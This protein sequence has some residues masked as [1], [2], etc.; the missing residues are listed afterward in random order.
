MNSNNVMPSNH[1]DVKC[2]KKYSRHLTII[3]AATKFWPYRCP[4]PNARSSCVSPS[5]LQ[6]RGHPCPVLLRLGR[7]ISAVGGVKLNVR[8]NPKAM[9]IKFHVIQI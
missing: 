6:P 1:V 7:N 9:S 3:L 4:V 5:L 2:Q 8:L